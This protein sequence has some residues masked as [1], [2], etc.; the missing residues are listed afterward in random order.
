MLF[1]LTIKIYIYIWIGIFIKIYSLENY[2]FIY[3]EEIFEINSWLQKNETNLYSFFNNNKNNS[4]IKFSNEVK[5]AILN[6][7]PIVALESVIISHG[8]YVIL[9]RNF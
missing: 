5:N 8:I 7:L 2:S 1:H 4:L 3:Q 9:I 6:D